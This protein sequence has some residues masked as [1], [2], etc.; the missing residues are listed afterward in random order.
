MATPELDAQRYMD[1]QARYAEKLGK[2]RREVLTDP[3]ELVE[4]LQDL[5]GSDPF[6]IELAAMFKAYVIW[7]DY[8]GNAY[9][10]CKTAFAHP[11]VKRLAEQI[12]DREE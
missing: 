8:E 12:A 7:S 3:N 6:T 5:D 9:T 1:E 10:L 11:I 2:A 4:F